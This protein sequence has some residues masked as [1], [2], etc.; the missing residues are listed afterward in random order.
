M[1]TKEELGR[2]LRIARFERNMT[3]K[4]VAQRCG[5]SATHISEVER[6]KTSPTIGALQ[7]IAAA[8]GEKPS[9][10]VRE[11]E[12]SRV[13]LTR[14]SGRCNLYVTD[15]RGGPYTIEVL[16]P[17]IPG[18]LTQ[19][20]ASTAK[21]GESYEGYPMI[22]EV[23]LY[24]NKGMVRVTAGGETHVIREGDTLQF[25]TD[26]GYRGENIGDDDSLVTAVLATPSR[27]EI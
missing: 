24:C 17:G 12:F 14:K 4:E 2:R 27:F 10:F 13:A 1:P 21:P 16:S 15:R 19:M 9:H 3:L 20:F 25:R 18:G 5:M 8:L 22:G 7:R 6:G 26:D 23:V 11:E